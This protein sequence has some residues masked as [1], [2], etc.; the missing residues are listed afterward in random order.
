MTTTTPSDY[1]PPQTKLS[2]AKNLPRVLLLLVIT[3][4]FSF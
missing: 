3:Q 4:I 2:L 1:L